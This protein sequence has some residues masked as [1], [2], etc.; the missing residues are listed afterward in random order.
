MGKPIEV[1]KF[2]S[3]SDELVAEYHEKYFKALQDLFEE[4]K[5]KYDEAGST[6]QL[7]VK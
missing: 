4:Y 5:G 6:S 2:E 3:P 1:P 7:I